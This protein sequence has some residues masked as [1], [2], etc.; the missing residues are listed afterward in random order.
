[1]VP[2]FG[3]TASPCNKQQAAHKVKAVSEEGCLECR[4]S[5]HTLSSWCLLHLVLRLMEPS[6]PKGKLTVKGGF[7]LRNFRV[8]EIFQLSYCSV[9]CETLLENFLL[10]C[11][12]SIWRPTVREDV[13]REYRVS[14][15]AALSISD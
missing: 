2:S 3:E 15:A 14:S 4:N 10:F 9:C 1:M 7:T 11:G 6:L 13:I 5:T 12:A 8:P